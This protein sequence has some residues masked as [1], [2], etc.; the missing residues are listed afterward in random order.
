MRTN[1][2]ALYASGISNA[3]LDGLTCSKCDSDVQVEMHHVRKLSDLNPKL[4]E[5]DKIMAAKLRKQIPLCRI[6]HMKYHKQSTVSR[7]RD[8]K[9]QQGKK[10]K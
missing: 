6:C 3:S 8:M 2:K 9:I 4:S 1:L 7:N 5:I 10:E